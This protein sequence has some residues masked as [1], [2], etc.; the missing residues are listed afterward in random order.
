[1][2]PTLLLSLLLKTTL[3]LVAGLAVAAMA[4]HAR[5]SL[6]H[7]VLASTFAVL[8]A[9]PFAVA[10]IR[11]VSVAVPFGSPSMNDA[12]TAAIGRP[13]LTLA[14]PPALVGDVAGA[15]GLRLSL[16][17]VLIAATTWAAGAGLFLAFLGVS[18]WKV[19]RLR[20]TSLP[21][22]RGRALLQAVSP[23]SPIDIDVLMHDG[24]AAPL[25]CGFINPAIILPVDAE[26]WS[27]HELEQ[28]FVHEAEHV[29]RGDWATQ[30]VARAVCAAYWF[31]P[32]AWVAWRRLCVECERA[33]DDAV[34]VRCERADYAEQL[35]SLARRTAAAPLAP[36]LLMVGRTDLSVRVRAILDGSQLRGRAGAAA[37]VAASAAA[38]AF[39]LAIAPLEAVIAGPLASQAAAIEPADPFTAAIAETFIEAAG[40]GRTIVVRAFL[41]RGADVNVV[42]PGDGTPLIAAAREGHTGIV[43]LL[44]ERGADPNIAVWG[45]GNPLTMA[46]RGGH[47][48]AATLLLDAGARL[49]DIVPGDENPLINASAE[50]HLPM[51]QLLVGRGAAVNIGSWAGPSLDRRG[52][53]WRTP[54]NMA[55]RNGHDTVARFLRGAGATN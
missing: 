31:H 55:L 28:A 5:A 25:T 47:L 11:P 40:Q 38:L 54:L 6:R 46:A 21:W 4:T 30:L 45:D 34:L 42:L 24:I 13:V 18:L 1:M 19:R 2:D 16:S 37:V 10:L 7:V 8:L 39:V 48:A 26:G 53:D 44:L 52:D 9:L 51:V 43:R 36:I 17:P 49:D 23:D 20:A 50:G 41:D 22:P 3:A 32:L 14:P 35:V 15:P 29:R 33:C 27:D 12:V